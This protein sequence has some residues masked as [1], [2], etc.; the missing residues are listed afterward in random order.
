MMRLMQSL[1]TIASML[2]SPSDN[3]LLTVDDT[4][5]VLAIH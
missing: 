4:D 5:K 2:K 3:A 1:D